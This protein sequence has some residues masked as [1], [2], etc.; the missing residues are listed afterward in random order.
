[1]GKKLT[2]AEEQQVILS[3]KSLF[4]TLQANRKKYLVIDWY[5]DEQP[6][7]K[8]KS[9]IEEALDKNLPVCYDKDLFTVKTNLLLNH[10]IDM[11]VQ[12][13]GWARGVVC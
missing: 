2:K 5:K 1:M 9:L 12:G 3:A 13:Y 7:E 8:V 11:A 10:L 6:R 4:E